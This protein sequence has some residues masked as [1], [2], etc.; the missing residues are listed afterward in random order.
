MIILHKYDNFT[1]YFRQKLDNLDFEEEMASKNHVLT[2]PVK[3]AKNFVTLDISL[4]V[5]CCAYED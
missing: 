4:N 3:H 5:F 1:G 2:N